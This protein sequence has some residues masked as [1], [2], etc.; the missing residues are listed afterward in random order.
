[1]TRLILLLAFLLLA[2]AAPAGTG[3]SGLFGA[4]GGTQ[5][6]AFQLDGLAFRLPTG[7]DWR[8]RREPDAISVTRFVAT[9]GGEPFAVHYIL[10][11]RQDIPDQLWDWI[12]PEIAMLYRE[13]ELRDMAELGVEAGVYSLSGVEF[14][15]EMRA[16]QTF[17]YLANLKQ[18]AE[19]GLEGWF[20][21]HQ[22]LYYLFP[23]DYAEEA[24]FYG[25]LVGAACVRPA[26]SP[27]DLGLEEL[28]PVLE[29]M[30]P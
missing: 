9:P 19:P 8:T 24:R 25:A 20:W 21:D 3:G 7:D 6:G 11:F 13:G 10:V 23:P 18:S 17:Y 5:W 4:G 30:R 28:L 15:E 22:R 2:T 16:G 1:M 27:D 29:S 14:G 26:C 12:A